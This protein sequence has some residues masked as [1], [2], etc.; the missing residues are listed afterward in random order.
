MAAPYLITNQLL[1]RLKVIKLVHLSRVVDDTYYE[2]VVKSLNTRS[3]KV[4]KTKIDSANL[5]EI[6]GARK[7]V[8][9]AENID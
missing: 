1:Y 9:V 6:T 8:L 7:Q 5:V 4:P 3:Q 2:T